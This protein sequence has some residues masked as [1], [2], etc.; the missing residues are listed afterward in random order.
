[1]KVND[2]VVVD[3]PGEPILHPNGAGWHRL[4][5]TNKDALELFRDLRSFYGDE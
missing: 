2:A 5:M 1:M 4:V 3:V